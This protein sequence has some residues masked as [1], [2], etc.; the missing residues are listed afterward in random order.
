MTGVLRLRSSLVVSVA[1]RV[2][3][4]TAI[5]TALVFAALWVEMRQASRDLVQGAIDTDLAGLVDTYGA[6]GPQGLAERIAER[7][8]F[9]PDPA[10]G[11]GGEALFY[12]LEDAGGRVLAGNLTAW[13]Q[14]R[15]EVSEA[16]EMRIAGGVPVQYRVTLLRGRMRLLVGRSVAARE[17]MLGRMAALFGVALVALVALA[18][19]IG[20]VAARSLGRRIAAINAVFGSFGREGAGDRA[21]VSHRGDEIDALSGHLNTVLDRIALLLVARKELSD[22]IA[23]ETRSPLMHIG[24]R[25]ARARATGLEAGADQQLD[26]AQ[27]DIRNLQRML[28]TLL[29]IASSEAQRGEMNSLPEMDLAEVASR[30]A[31]LYEPTAEDMG[32]TFIARIAPHVPMRGEPVQMSSLIV[33][34]L[35]NAFKYGADGRII[36]LIV[37]P[38]PRLVVEDEGTGIPPER[39]EAIFE[40][41]TRAHQRGKGHGLGLA[42][43]RAIAERHG[44]AIK[45]ES[46]IPAG[47]DAGSQED[48]EQAKGARFVV[49]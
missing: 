17:A 33:N 49:G 30:L 44:L 25:I 29:D 45:V 42:L 47:P 38:G 9:S 37:E 23:H 20:R 18:W 11:N 34:L 10:Q 48:H 6:Q 14:A 39:R 36:R 2:A 3:L 32:I 4:A 21:P 26:A 24:A 28:D 19:A 35:D 46:T 5:T 40:R 1:V 15:A 7:L 41:F 13:P 27:G 8:A 31:E 43:V 16:G 22:A 12:R